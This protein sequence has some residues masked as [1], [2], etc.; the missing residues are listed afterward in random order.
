[1]KTFADNA[2]R[3]WLVCLNVGALKR[4]RAMAS[5]DLLEVVDGKLI[6]RLVRD[7]VL[8]CDVLYAVCKPEAESR[9]V[10]EDEFL[11]SLSGDVIDQATRALFEE[12]VDFFPNPRDRVNLKR[13]LDA[14]WAVMDRARDLVEA[15]LTSGAL[16]RAAEAAL[17]SVMRSSGAALESSASTQSG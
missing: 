2:G 9:G 10:S 12:I 5:V 1:M 4:V 7:P 6:E 11:S 3:T 14:T 15:R 13:V 8:L 16:E 17:E